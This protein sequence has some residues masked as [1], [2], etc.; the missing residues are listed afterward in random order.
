M[1]LPSPEPSVEAG[2]LRS[3]AIFDRRHLRMTFAGVKGRHR[4]QTPTVVDRD[5]LPA[6]LPKSAASRDIRRPQISA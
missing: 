6:L 5:G 3:R 1:A 4:D 2:D